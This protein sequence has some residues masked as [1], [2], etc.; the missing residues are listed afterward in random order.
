VRI[1]DRWLQ[2]WRIA[3]AVP[4]VREGD[5]LL[6]VGCFDRSLLDR[7]AGRIASGVGIDPLAEPFE[8][9][10]LRMLK[11]HFP[12]DV[13]LPDGSFDCITMLAV[14]EHAEDPD[15]VAGA[16][17]RLLRP[18]GRAILTVPHP[19]VDPI[20]DALVFVGLADGMS[21]EEHHGFDVGETAPIFERAGFRLLAARRFQLGLN[22]LFVFE[23]L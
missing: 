10:R 19:A 4:W 1:L 14:F 5:R 8:G 20:I 12:E 18:G 9:E 22:R 21:L 17:H 7:V 16:C 15:A 3:K 2:R 13:G 23:R 6:D 11:G